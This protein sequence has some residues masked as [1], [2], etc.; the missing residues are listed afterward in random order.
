LSITILLSGLCACATLPGFEKAY[1]NPSD[2]RF[3]RI[4]DAFGPLD[5]QSS[6]SIIEQISEGTVST[7]NLVRL[8][9]FEEVVSGCPLVYGNRLTLFSSGAEAY[10]AMIQTISGAKKNINFETYIFENDEVGKQFSRLLARKQ[11][12]GVQVNIIYDSLGSFGPMGFLFDEIE[13]NGGKVVA[14]RPL[15]PLHIIYPWGLNQRDHR[16]I[17]LVDGEIAFTGGINIS[18]VYLAKPA[19]KDTAPTLD[20][21]KA[22]RDAHVMMEG[23]A[24]RELQSLFA[25]SWKEEEGESLKN[26][27]YFPPL[28]N[29]GTHLVRVIG[30]TPQCKQRPIYMAYLSAITHAQ[31]YVHIS[32]AYFIPGRQIIEALCEAAKRGVEVVLILPSFSNVKLAIHAGRSYYKKLLEN[33]VNIYEMKRMFLHSKTAVVDGTWS[34]I[35]STN[36]DYRGF[37]HDHQVNVIIYGSDFAQELDSIFLEDLEASEQITLEKWKKRPLSHRLIEWFGRLVKYWL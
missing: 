17:V 4:I 12:E 25:K 8:M 30:T 35:G 20:T 9:S 21:N 29:K 34:T 16:K 33:G 3:P 14:F 15:N 36:L 5:R 37:L 23:P 10:A 31:K 22:C 27:D 28:K 6:I 18:Q 7:A 11:V 26:E 1:F 2:C 24:V 19:T 13:E 32:M